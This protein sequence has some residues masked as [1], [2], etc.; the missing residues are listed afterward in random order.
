MSDTLVK[1]RNIYDERRKVTVEVHGAEYGDL[2]ERVTSFTNDLESKRLELQTM[3][4]LVAEA[5]RL[6]QVL[7]ETW[8]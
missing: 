2:R 1:L 3:S 7:S 5:G 8:K 6:R 4:E